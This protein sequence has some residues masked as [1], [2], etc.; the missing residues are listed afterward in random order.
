MALQA[1]LKYHEIAKML[2]TRFDALRGKDLGC[3]THLFGPCVFGCAI[4]NDVLNVPDSQRFIYSG[5]N[6]YGNWQP[7]LV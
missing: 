1:A 2:L 4:T 6:A 7:G 5:N 3:S